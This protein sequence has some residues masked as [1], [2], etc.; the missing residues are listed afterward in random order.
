M[1]WRDRLG[2]LP[3]EQR[4]LIEGGGL[5]QRFSK[6]P[7]GI[8]HPALIGAFYGILITLTLLLPLGENSNWQKNWVRDWAWIGVWIILLN[9]IVSHISLLVAG[10]LR[11]PPV[12]LPRSIVYPMPF[13]GLILFTIILI[14]DLENNLPDPLILPAQYF[15]LMLLLIPGPIYVHMTWAPRWRLLCKLEDN[16]DPFEGE[17]YTPKKTEL[18]DLQSDADFDSAIESIEKEPPLINQNEEE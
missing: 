2:E 4:N 3:I 10:I 11:R 14:T 16:L 17:I 6:M 1:T 5:S 7:L 13:L 18:E 12:S 9:A 15:S 8:T